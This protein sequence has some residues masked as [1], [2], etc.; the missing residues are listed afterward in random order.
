MPSANLSDAE[1]DQVDR[2][3]AVMKAAGH[4]HLPVPFGVVRKLV[5]VMRLINRR[6]RGVW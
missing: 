4:T 2:D 5:A 6:S 3:I 1:L